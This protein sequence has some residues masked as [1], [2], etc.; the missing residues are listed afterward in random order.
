MPIKGMKPRALSQH[1]RAALL[2]LLY[3]NGAMSIKD[4]SL[5]SGLS[6]P[7]V[8]KIV[9]KLTAEGFAVNICPDKPIHGKDQGLWGINKEKEY[10]LCF[11][12]TPLFIRS[13]VINY[14]GESV[15]E[16]KYRNE[17]LTDIRDIK[18]ILLKEY[19][20]W[21]RKYP[22]IRRA[23]MAVT[24]IVDRESGV[25]QY[26]ALTKAQGV[27]NFKELL[28]R[29]FSLKLKIENNCNIMAL[30]EKWLGRHQDTH[31]FAIVHADYGVGAALIQENKLFR[32]EHLTSL[33]LGHISANLNGIQCSCGARGCIEAY[34]NEAALTEKSGSSNIESFYEKLEALEPLS[35]EIYRKATSYLA[36]G[37]GVLI[38]MF[39]PNKIIFYGSFTR[40]NFL[41][42]LEHQV[43]SCSLRI[44][45]EGC[46]FEISSL[47]PEQYLSGAAFLWIEDD[48][49][50]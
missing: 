12:I 36:L 31:S 41:K 39:S 22:K 40:G 6:I 11:D 38:N 14:L 16:V 13:A 20:F 23:G 42:Q 27:I 4:I 47:S 1:N 7:A 2:R 24:G 46:S 19:S 34:I 30:A 21:L 45:S 48:L 18:T 32:G 33:Q 10:F 29:E 35:L 28:E 5:N 8:S 15:S 44:F 3:Q 43:S 25:S 17:N 49:H 26:R 37:T 9:K 50:L